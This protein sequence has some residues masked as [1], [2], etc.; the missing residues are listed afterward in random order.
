MTGLIGD[1]FSRLLRLLVLVAGMLGIHAC[2]HSDSLPAEELNRLANK[3]TLHLPERD[4]EGLTS[5]FTDTA[6][7]MSPGG[8][9]VKGREVIHDFWQRYHLPIAWTSRTRGITRDSTPI[10]HASAW[11]NTLGEVPATFYRDTPAATAHAYLWADW[12]IDYEDMAG[13]TRSEE[14]AVLLQWVHTAES[15]WRINKLYF[16]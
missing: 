16:R 11:I 13:I 15:G 7:L 9:H 14:L 4:Y 1:T 2:S 5:W 8:Y 10:Q 3:I 12:K 6:E